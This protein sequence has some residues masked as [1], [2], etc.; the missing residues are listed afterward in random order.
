VPLPNAR[1]HLAAYCVQPRRPL[2]G[3]GSGEWRC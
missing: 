2:S 1:H 3:G